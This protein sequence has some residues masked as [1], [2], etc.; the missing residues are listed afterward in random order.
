MKKSSR[1]SWSL[2]VLGSDCLLMF[3]VCRDPSK[4]VFLFELIGK[5]AVICQRF[6]HIMCFH[7]HCVT[8]YIFRRAV[9]VSSRIARLPTDSAVQKSYNVQNVDKKIKSKSSESI[10]FK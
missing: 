4:F 2:T 10:E 7:I 8:I 6:S 5:A 3:G 1:R 9:I